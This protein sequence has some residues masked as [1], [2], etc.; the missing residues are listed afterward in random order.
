MERTIVIMN[1]HNIS[2]D[3][4]LL[5]CE[6]LKELE[7]YK[8]IY[9]EL[10]L[11][12]DATYD[13]IVI[14]D[15]KGV[16]L[17]VSK[18]CEKSF[19]ISEDEMIG[20]SAKELE[21]RGVLSKSTAAYVAENKKKVTLIQTTKSGS[22]LMVTGIPMFDESGEIIRIISISRDVTELEKLK[23]RLKETEEILNWFREEMRKKQSQENQ[24][25]TGNN[26]MMKYIIEN[27]SQVSN[28]NVIVLLT[29][30][31]GVGKSLIA[32][33]IH[34]MSN[35]RQE[36][37]V[38]VNCG[39]IPENLLESELFG[40]V[41]GAFTGASKKGKKG[42]FEAASGGTLFL[43]E[44]GEIPLN[45]Q[46]KLLHV[47]ENSYIN[48]IGKTTPIKIDTRIVVATN[49]NL[50]KLVEEGKFREDLYY[51]LNVVPIHIPSL[52]ERKEDIPILI[53]HFID[54]LNAKFGLSK[55]ISEEGYKLLTS[56]DW[57]G[58]IRQLEN[59][60]ERL[61]ITVQKD[62][63]DMSHIINVIGPEDVVDTGLQGI[64]PLKQARE[65]V[66][67]RIIKEALKKYKTTRKVA[68]VLEVDQS[69]IVK[70]M[71]RYNIVIGEK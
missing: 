14:A 33:T 58:N 28:Y 17:R 67:T 44:I 60:I 42:L 18:S 6:I 47:I 49:K 37:F 13:E 30:E 11:I 26:K 36:P 27:L 3:K 25:V 5:D 40:Y 31:T 65:A 4:S 16:I 22:R 39:A 63:I 35:R 53:H 43:D 48:K 38:H 12:L 68:E 70:K 54:K 71:Q 51:R 64:I 57:P 10:K 23:S 46:V 52:R 45:V 20:V 21:K 69:T 1:K 62:T 8:Q 2:C 34:Q 19:G 7:H 9:G 32:K 41:E 59:T 24:L 29:G 66:E 55:S 61:L 15:G 56:Y 50:K